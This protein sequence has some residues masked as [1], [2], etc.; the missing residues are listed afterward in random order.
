MTTVAE[1]LQFLLES[2]DMKQTELADRIGISKQSLYKYLH[3]KCE[4]R[5]EVIAKMAAALSTSADFIVGLT[6]D[7]TPRQRDPETEQRMEKQTELTAKVQKLTPVN[8]IRLEERLDCLLEQQ[9]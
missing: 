7:P 8:R 3:C 4:P 6:A 2:R 9:G 1:R 5:S